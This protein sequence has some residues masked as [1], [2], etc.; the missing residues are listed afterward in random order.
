V[1]EYSVGREYRNKVDSKL[2]AVCIAAEQGVYEL[3]K[4][5]GE[6]QLPPGYRTFWEIITGKSGKRKG[7]DGDADMEDH[8][9]KKCRRSNN[10]SVEQDE[11][12]DA[13]VEVAPTKAS[14]L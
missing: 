6:A 7:P 4:F 13:E 8:E 3:L 14:E 2:A 10:G 1:Q 9:R 11:V 12:V 5:R